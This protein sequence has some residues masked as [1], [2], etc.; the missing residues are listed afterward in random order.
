MDAPPP[1]SG[2]PMRLRLLPP[3]HD[4][5]VDDYRLFDREDVLAEHAHAVKRR[6]PRASPC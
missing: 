5:T 6:R 4:G 1:R 3:A 2:S